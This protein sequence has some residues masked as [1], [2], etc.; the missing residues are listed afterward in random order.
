MEESCVI[1]LDDDEEEEVI[2]L[3]DADDQQQSFQMRLSTSKLSETLNKSI[4]AMSITEMLPFC[5]PLTSMP[6]LG[7][8]VVFKVRNYE[9]YYT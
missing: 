8:I 4:S 5:T 7:D 3:S 6:A 9:I 2:D 1:D